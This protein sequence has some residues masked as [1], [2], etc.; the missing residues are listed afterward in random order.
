MV[1]E[2][3]LLGAEGDLVYL[4]LPLAHSFALLIQLGAVDIGT[5]LA[6]FGGDPKQ[7][8]PELMQVN[9][10]YLPSV[11]RIFEK[12]YTLAPGP[13][14]GA[15]DRGD[16]RPRRPDPRP[17]APAA[18]RSRRSCRPLERF[19]RGRRAGLLVARSCAQRCSAATCARPSPAPRRSP[20]RS[21]VLL[22][23]RR[24]RARGLRDDRDRDRRDDLDARAPQVR[25]GRP[26]RC[27]ASR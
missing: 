11:P 1:N 5:T 19:D 26:A 8:I 12:I 14:P 17:R 9:P 4:F 3:G 22:R 20:P 21:C 27:R 16:Q 10:T 25:H 24:P 13:D 23:R 2:R 6:Y 15:G 7:I 18:S